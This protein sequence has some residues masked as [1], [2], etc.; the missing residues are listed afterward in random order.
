MQEAMVCTRRSEQQARQQDCLVELSAL[1]AR[2]T[3]RRLGRRWGP[4]KLAPGHHVMTGSSRFSVT[5]TIARHVTAKHL[6]A[7]AT[8]S[9]ANALQLSVSAPTANAHPMG[10]NGDHQMHC[11]LK[12]RPSAN[13]PP[14]PHALSMPIATH[15]KTKAAT[16]TQAAA[17]PVRCQPS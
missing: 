12:A 11:D 14:S 9:A 4:F 8:T 17:A 5:P 13:H 16:A 10:G 6:P 2:I 15:C 7:G 3:A 1:R